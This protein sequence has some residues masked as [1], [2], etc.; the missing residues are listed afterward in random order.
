[1]FQDLPLECSSMKIILY[2]G[3][4]ESGAPNHALTVVGNSDMNWMYS[5]DD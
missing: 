2:N 5:F 1:M 3:L 4:K